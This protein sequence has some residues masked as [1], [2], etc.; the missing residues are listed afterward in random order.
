LP[1]PSILLKRLFVIAANYSLFFRAGYDQKMPVLPIRGGWG[2]DGNFQTFFDHL[3]VYGPAEIEPLADG[4][5]GGEYMID[6][7]EIH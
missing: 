7:C 3:R 5:G 4:T 1:R 6:A 2:L